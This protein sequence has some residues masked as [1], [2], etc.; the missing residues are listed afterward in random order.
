[1][2]GRDVLEIELT[3]AA[4]TTGAY[5]E[6]LLLPLVGD[7]ALAPCRCRAGQHDGTFVFEPSEH[8]AVDDLDDLRA[9]GNHYLATSAN[10]LFI[11]RKLSI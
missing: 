3:A 2:S 7:A 10:L 11:E 5:P 9:A 6:P 4:A 8:P 1:M